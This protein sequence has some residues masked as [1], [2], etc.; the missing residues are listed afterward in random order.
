[1]PV[2]FLEEVQ[3]YFHF[4]PQKSG[5]NKKENSIFCPARRVMASK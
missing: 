5:D 2:L 1:M 3:Q 4:F